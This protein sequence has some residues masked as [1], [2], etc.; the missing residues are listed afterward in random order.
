MWNS[1]SV[2]ETVRGLLLKLEMKLTIEYSNSRYMSKKWT[3]YIKEIPPL[4]CLIATL[5]TFDFKKVEN[6]PG[7]WIERINIMRM[8]MLPTELQIQHKSN[9]NSSNIL[10]RF[11]KNKMLNFV[12]KSKR[13][14][15]VKAVLNN[16]NKAGHTIIP[17]FRI[18]RGS[19]NQNSL[20]LYQK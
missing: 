12:W 2:C 17:K 18:L 1:I 4:P 9:H 16:R 19:S 10:L 8:S 11:G 5:L 20:V 3:Q 6:L 13:S 7:L 15:I 14:W